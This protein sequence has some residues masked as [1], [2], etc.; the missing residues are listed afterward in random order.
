M[1]YRS[2][3]AALAPLSTTIS[4]RYARTG[5]ALVVAVKDPA[6][7]SWMNDVRR[8]AVGALREDAR[9]GLMVDLVAALLGRGA[10][11]GSTRTGVRITSRPPG[12]RVTVDNQPVGVTD[13]EYAVIP[14][15]HVISR[16]GATKPSVAVGSRG[17]LVGAVGR[18]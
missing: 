5:T 12:A 8:T 18:F 17:L 14:G 11:A 2:L 16:C 10:S 7:T 9:K 4:A 6:A 3:I 13:L 15:D 1:N